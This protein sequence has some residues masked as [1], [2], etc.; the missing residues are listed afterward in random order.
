MYGWANKLM[1]NSGAK[2]QELKETKRCDLN[3]WDFFFP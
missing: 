2:I 1:N 3:N